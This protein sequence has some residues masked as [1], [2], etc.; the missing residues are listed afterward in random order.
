MYL[1]IYIQRE[2]EREIHVGILHIR[3]CIWGARGRTRGSRSAANLQYT[4][5]YCTAL[6]Y[7]VLYCTILYCIILYYTILYYTVIHHNITYNTITYYIEMSYFIDLRRTISA[8]RIGL[9]DTG[10]VRD[11]D[12]CRPPLVLVACFSIIQ[13]CN[14]RFY[15]YHTQLLVV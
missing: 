4:R 14:I 13:P 15:Y 8:F 10:E 9:R 2:R 5:L 6:Y 3:T 12:A 1:Y 11:E 7:T